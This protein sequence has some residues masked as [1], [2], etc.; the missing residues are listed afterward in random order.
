[1]SSN[2]IY[3]DWIADDRWTDEE[4]IEANPKLDV[5]LEAVRDFVFSF[6]Y[7]PDDDEELNEFIYKAFNLIVTED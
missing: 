5:P 6:G 7:D 2:V 3:I 4:A 1:M